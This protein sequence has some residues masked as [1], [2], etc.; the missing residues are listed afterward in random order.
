MRPDL[1]TANHPSPA[2][3]LER[4]VE[5][6]CSASEGTLIGLHREHSTHVETL[7]LLR[8][9]AD[10]RRIIA[11]R[12]AR[13]SGYGDGGRFSWFSSISPP[14]IEPVGFGDTLIQLE[15]LLIEHQDTG[16]SLG[17]TVL[18]LGQGCAMALTLA[19]LWP[20]LIRGVIAVDAMWPQAPGWT[21]LGRDMASVRALVVGGD[22]GTREQLTSRGADLTEVE[23]I[24]SEPLLAE[25]CRN[26]SIGG[27]ARSRS[28]L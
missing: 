25:L 17:T 18:G 13:W 5:A 1:I 20:E 12:S 24:T 3:V 28:P 26:W 22:S 15:S 2:C 27:L 21:L 19:A 7:P 10:G 14:L 23:P 16:S 8:M 9:V 6:D 4:V 11:P